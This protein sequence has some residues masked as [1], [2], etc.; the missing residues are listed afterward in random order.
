[1]ATSYTGRNSLYLQPYPDCLIVGSNGAY[2]FYMTR[3]TVFPTDRW[4]SI[5]ELVAMGRDN[6]IALQHEAAQ[7]IHN[8]ENVYGKNG[9]SRIVS[10][11]SELSLINGKRSMKYIFTGG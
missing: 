9:H 11:K 3:S 8:I 1:M 10:Y 5:D 2:V 6:L 4:P 7:R